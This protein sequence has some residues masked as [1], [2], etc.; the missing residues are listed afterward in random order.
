[1]STGFCSSDRLVMC[2]REGSFL[3]YVF[4]LGKR[5]TWLT[6]QEQKKTKTKILAVLAA[7]FIP[8]EHQGHSSGKASSHQVSSLIPHLQLI[9]I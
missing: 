3:R 8:M 7:V 1:M 9:H 6:G 2:G 5:G 4:V